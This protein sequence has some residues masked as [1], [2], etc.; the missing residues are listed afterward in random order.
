[1]LNA[2]CKVLNRLLAIFYDS[3]M[4]LTLSLHMS[5]RTIVLGF[6]AYRLPCKV[7]QKTG[8]VRLFEMIIHRG[9]QKQ[10]GFHCKAEPASHYAGQYVRICSDARSERIIW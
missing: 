5:Y 8:C 9:N 6:K 2:I 10:S 7:E 4:L 1:M 3:L